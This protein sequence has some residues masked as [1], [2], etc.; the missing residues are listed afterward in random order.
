MLSLQRAGYEVLEAA[1]G[2]EALELARSPQARAIDLLI[3]DFEMPRMNGAQLIGELKTRQPDLL[4]IVLTGS[5]PG[6]LPTDL[7][8]QTNLLIRKPVHSEE[9]LHHVNTLLLARSQEL[10]TGKSLTQ[11][12]GN[13][14]RKF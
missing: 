13:E 4:V 9:L 7:T 14:G 8:H 10:I 1:D 12:K 6:A 2:L 11:V 5:N 3:S